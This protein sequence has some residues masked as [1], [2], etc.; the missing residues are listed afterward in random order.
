MESP[1]PYQPHD[2][3]MGMQPNFSQPPTNSPGSVDPA[4]DIAPNRD[5]PDPGSPV[6][7]TIALIAVIV[8][9]GAVMLVQ[10][11]SNV[12]PTASKEKVEVKAPSGFTPIEGQIYAYVKYWGFMESFAPTPNSGPNA[13]PPGFVGNLDQGKTAIIDGIRTVQGND[14]EEVRSAMAVAFV[15]GPEQGREDLTAVQKSLEAKKKKASQS[16]DPAATEEFPGLENDINLALNVLDNGADS[17]SAEENKSLVD[18]HGY[19]A[20]LL[21]V[22]DKPMGSSERTALTEGG[23]KMIGLL[24]LLVVFLF[25]VAIAAITCFII[26]MVRLGSG[27][28]KPKFKAPLPGGSIFLES[29]AVFAAGFLTLKVGMDLF[30]GGTGGP[31]GAAAPSMIAGVLSM[32]LQWGLLLTVFWPRLR[33]VPMSELSRRIG[34][35]KGEGVMKEIGAG[36]FAY[37]ATLPI[38]LLVVLVMLAVM[39]LSAAA[40]GFGGGGGDPMQPP[41]NPI[42]DAIG[43]GN[44]LILGMLFLL[45]TMWAPF[46][47]ESLFR[48]G[49]FRHLR[50]R[51]G[52]LLAALLSTIAFGVMHNY[53]WML[54]AP[55]MTLGFNFALMREWRGSLIAPMFAHAMHNGTVLTIAYFAISTLSVPKVT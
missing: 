9:V 35:T 30:A 45:A 16:A 2:V 52:V 17:I 50:S 37:F 10:Q 8:L 29:L 28:I 15:A 1:N 14:L 55:V 32:I 43:S 12:T 3:S 42:F 38:F 6:A 25:L 47:E 51:M 44:P 40:S 23:G 13:T 20:K 41:E 5:T 54:L 21:F 33:G 26:A 48:G 46:V 49:L 4:S 11:L 53:P 19:F 27:K 31:G 24:V 18:R 22:A 34:W 36:V 7:R 39:F